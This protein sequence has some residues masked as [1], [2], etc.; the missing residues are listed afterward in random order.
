MASPK[1]TNQKLARRSSQARTILIR[2]DSP[3][4]MA[5]K[6]DTDTHHGHSAIDL[7][8]PQDR[9]GPLDER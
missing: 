4:E 2:I 7:G 3:L 1:G 9:K 5:R 8:F 6:T